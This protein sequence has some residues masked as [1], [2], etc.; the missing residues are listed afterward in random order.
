MGS[1]AVPPKLRSQRLRDSARATAEVSPVHAHLL[2]ELISQ[3]ELLEALETFEE[4]RHLP[5]RSADALEALAFYA[6]RLGLH[7]VSNDYYRQASALEPHNS[8][9]LHNLATSERSLGRMEEAIDACNRAIQAHPDPFPSILLRSECV[10]ARHG[11]N[12]LAELRTWLARAREPRQKMFLGYALGKELHD[13]GEY[14]DAFP[15]FA[16]AAQARRSQLQYDVKQDVKKLSR[17]I[18]VFQG[19]YKTQLLSEGPADHIFIVGLP[20]TGTTL[21]ERILSGLNG[22]VSNGET[23]NFSRALI[24]ASPA[25][26]EDIFSRAQQADSERCNKLYCKMAN[27]RNVKIS[28]IDKLPLN[29]L[30]VGPILKSISRTRIIWINRDPVDSCFAMWRTLF[31]EA[32][33]FSYDFKDLAC[34]FDIYRKLQAHWHRVAGSDILNVDYA[35]LV[36]SPSVVGQ[37]MA[38]H[39]GLEWTDEAVDISR[40]KSASLT[41]SAAQVREG[42]YTSSNGIWQQYERHLAPLIAALRPFGLTS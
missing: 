15:A 25:H 40:V 19:P 38:E 30:Y 17:I 10:R 6:Q 20:R 11:A 27:P 1:E 16:M 12:H 42:I 39:C 5:A 3:G 8:K 4:L 21:T 28:T 41:A 23:D 32:Y 7:D 33:P 9:L 18:E 37:R 26:G 34:Y 29:Y 14:N 13:L 2:A 31:A 22:V 24:M 35:E 36:R